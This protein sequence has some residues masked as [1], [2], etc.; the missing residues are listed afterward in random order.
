MQHSLGISHDGNLYV[1]NNNV[2][3][4]NN[5]DS[6]ISNIVVFKE[7]KT[8]NDSLT[9]VWEFYCDIDSNARHAGAREGNVVQLSD[10]SFICCMGHAN[11]IFIVDSNKRVQFNCLSEQ[12]DE[13]QKKWV[14]FG[15]YRICPVY[16]SDMKKFSSL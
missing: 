7:P 2:G 13:A 10:G 15:Q 5:P 6:A 1:F 11:R 14:E 8:A 12:W 16:Q 3:P 9:K 4:K